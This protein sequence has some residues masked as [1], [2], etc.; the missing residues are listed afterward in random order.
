MNMTN[1]IAFYSYGFACLSFTLLACALLIA[2][3]NRAL[4]IAILVATVMTAV[5]TGMVTYSIW[6]ANEP[7]TLLQVV[8][9][10]Y[11]V[12]WILLLLT[13]YGARLRDTD[14]PLGSRRWISWAQIGLAAFLIVLFGTPELGRIFG[15]SAVLTESIVFGLWVSLNLVG[16]L[17]LENI[18][19]NSNDLERWWVRYLCLGVGFL[20]LYDFLMYTD[21]LVFREIDQQLWESRGFAI[22]LS[23]PLMA[24]AA[25]RSRN[26]NTRVN[27]SRH[28]A[29][30]TF[31]LLLAGTYLIFMAVVGYFVKYLGGTWGGALQVFFLSA[32]GLILCVL[33][34]SNRVRAVSLVWLSKHFFSYKYD[35]RR[36]WL[37]FTKTL[38][39]QGPKDQ[40]PQTI[41]RAMAKLAN[42]RAGLLWSR[43]ENGS[44][45][46]EA[47]WNTELSEPFGEVP[48]FIDWLQSS[49]WVVDVQEWRRSPELYSG[50][51]MP[52]SLAEV[53]GSWLVVPLIF[54][55]RLE[56]ILVLRRMGTY[57]PLNWEDRDLLK[58]AGRQAANH[59]TQYHANQSL[60]ELRQFEGFSRLS[61]Y[62]IHDLKNI[63]AEQS[64]IV[65]NSVRHRGNIEFFDDVIATVGDSVQRM[66]RLMAQ[67]GGEL[68]GGKSEPVEIDALLRQVLAT[69][70]I[71]L[72]KPVLEVKV[73]NLWVQT[74][75]DQLAT[76]FSHLIKNAMEATHREGWVCVRLSRV[77]D[78]VVVEIE[79]D[80]TGMSQ[81]FIQQRLFKPFDSTKGLTGMGIGAFESREYVR[82]LG[83]NIYVRSKVGEGSCFRV[84]LPCLKQETA[85]VPVREVV[86]SG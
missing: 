51:Q 31:T 53:R 41:I 7:T 9:V 67:I 35:Y 13:I 12:A 78:Q 15:I 57:E 50:L 18:Y 72:P 11:D 80:G 49:G 6:R 66:T 3:R 83:G 69:R 82:S 85:R 79:D 16:L 10:A 62:V 65:A 71:F 29:F 26:R 30:H 74:D 1:D 27:L 48:D 20:F 61:A 24:I 34:F 33:I 22:A 45:H 28:V 77:D 64:L 23:A 37:E 59:L 52:A 46:L 56:G 5:W 58:L 39:R 84:V 47:Q 19:R 81:E 60:V 8:E 54:S 4:S 42:C 73:T 36:E 44:F 75:R 17:L 14:H 76:V 21:A 32:T 68:R 70:A 86:G 40:A 55:G 63:L 43:L 25:A 38:E 2:W